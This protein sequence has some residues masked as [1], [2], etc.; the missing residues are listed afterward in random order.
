MHGSPRSQLTRIT[1]SLKLIVLPTS[2]SAY[3]NMVP[4]S[5]DILMLV[6]YKTPNDALALDNVDVSTYCAGQPP[7]QSVK[8]SFV[9]SQHSL[10]SFRC[11]TIIK[12]SRAFGA[13][14]EMI[15]GSTLWCWMHCTWIPRKLVIPSRFISWKTHF[16]ILA[17][18]AFTL[19]RHNARVNSHQRWKQ[20][21]FRVCF[22][23]WCEL[24]NTM[25]VISHPP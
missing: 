6:S 2:Q 25:S 16:L 23:L 15:Q 8:S 4:K 7:C 22:H 21:R 19:W 1:T 11:Q 5:I 24:T 10:A 20:T 17:G 3:D 9:A 13:L 18:R 12:F 14:S